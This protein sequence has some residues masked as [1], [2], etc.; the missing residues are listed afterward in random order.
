MKDATGNTEG[1]LRV[2]NSSVNLQ[3]LQLLSSSRLY[4]R[5][6]AR[7]LGKDETE[8]SRRLSQL[9][10]AGLIECKWER[11][12]DRNVKLCYSLVKRVSL[13]FSSGGVRVV[14]EKPGLEEGVVKTLQGLYSRDIPEPRNFIGRK[15]YLERMFSSK[16]PVIVVWGLPG[17]GKTYLVAKY[18]S[19]VNKPV[20]WYH[21]TQFSNLRHF[22]WKTAIHLTTLGNYELL[23]V[24]KSPWD[25]S[26][27]LDIL[28]KGVEETSTIIVLDDYHKLVDRELANA[29]NYL[30]NTIVNARII[31][32]SR[33]RPS[34]LPY[35]KGLVEEIML[36][37]MDFNETLK[38]LD[39]RG[40]H[41]SDREFTELYVATQGIP[42]LLS[43]YCETRKAYGDKA[44][45]VLRKRDLPLYIIEEV[46][47][48]LSPSEKHVFDTLILIEEPVELELIEY[49]TRVRNVAGIL[50]S[51]SKRGFIEVYGGSKYII[52]DIFRMLSRRI[53]LD[54]IRSIYKNIGDY[55]RGLNNLFKA[56]RYYYI[57]RD[58]SGVK[59]VVKERIIS[60]T[61]YH[62][63]Y[64]GKY[65]DILK[66][67][68]GSRIDDLELKT[69][70]E[71]E[72]GHLDAIRGDYD[73]AIEMLSS[74]LKYFEK[75]VSD[76]DKYMYVMIG[77]SLAE[78]YS[79]K[80][81]SDRA[82]RVIVSIKDIPTSISSEDLLF[83]ARFHLYGT[84]GLYY[85]NLYDYR[86]AL[87]YYEE[88]LKVSQKMDDPKYYV[89]TLLGLANIYEA[90][91][92]DERALDIL[93]DVYNF[94]SK[95]GY[96]YMKALTELV[97]ADIYRKMNRFYDALEYISKAY[98]VFV[99]MNI[100]SK[101]AEA[102]NVRS[103][104]EYR[105]RD[106]SRS[107][108]DAVKV[109]EILKN[110]KHCYKAIA[111]SLM[112]S[113]LLNMGRVDEAIELLRK[114]YGFIKNCFKQDPVQELVNDVVC[115]L[116]EKGYTS[117]IKELGISLN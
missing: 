99:R 20:L 56:L 71:Y 101:Q 19:G 37:G 23:E 17:I 110:T 22:I 113:S 111:L 95:T 90:L 115:L 108:S 44:L 43:L 24:I 65:L 32:V 114:H 78:A 92:E 29:I 72:I 81:F 18:V 70:L 87:E 47:N 49:V 35:L 82:W 36:K 4:S 88:R 93:E 33:R 15:A 27:A 34:G 62:T 116:K 13:E 7:I 67:I 28:V 64:M 85:Y 63:A 98:S 73:S 57:A 11:I 16:K 76:Y 41:I 58:Y 109:Y 103:Y 66:E 25:P 97:I 48:M 12:R 31:V 6:I 1:V 51:F 59:D 100:V 39:S 52:H 117:L 50:D 105:L 38:L 112:I 8:V 55:Y 74:C 104:I 68:Y 54:R 86:K 45:E 107:Y 83:K 106:Y 96:T 2:L 80:G 53:S 89:F 10:K 21:V 46:Y 60:D 26:I 9:K 69:L 42:A 61:A 30:S 94:M 75:P 91:D 102:L 5:E 3:I 40:I 77:T 79:N 14:I 84:L